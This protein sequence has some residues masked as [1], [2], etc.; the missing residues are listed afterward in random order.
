MLLF[1]KPE[2]A[3]AGKT[4]GHNKLLYLNRTTVGI[5]SILSQVVLEVQLPS[6]TV[7]K[8]LVKNIVKGY[9]LLLK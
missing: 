7:L 6:S 9:P 8:T 1:S 3:E 2:G 5:I 4:A